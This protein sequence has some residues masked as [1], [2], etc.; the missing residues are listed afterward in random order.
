MRPEHWTL[1]CWKE[2]KK[3]NCI[4]LLP[5]AWYLSAF[6][7][8]LEK[9]ELKFGCCKSVLFCNWKDTIGVRIVKTA[10]LKISRPMNNMWREGEGELSL[11]CWY[12]FVHQLQSILSISPLWIF[13]N[14]IILGGVFNLKIFVWPIILLNA[15]IL[16]ICCLCPLCA[17]HYCF[18][19]ARVC[20]TAACIFLPS[21]TPICYNL[22]NW[23]L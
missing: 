22:I 3:W 13:H 15:V 4:G 17:V 18:P 10:L 23:I 5:C 21:S 7:T 20:V 8:T 16:C 6:K 12:L 19:V 9:D 2:R 1:P 14:I 11:W